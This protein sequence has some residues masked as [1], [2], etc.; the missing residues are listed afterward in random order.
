MWEAARWLVS[1]TLLES[2]DTDNLSAGISFTAVLFHGDDSVVFPTEEEYKREHKCKTAQLQDLLHNSCVVCGEEREDSFNFCVFRRSTGEKKKKENAR[3]TDDEVNGPHK[4]FLL[5]IA[6]EF[7]KVARIFS[8]TFSYSNF[9]F[10]LS[11]FFKRKKKTLKTF[12][13][14]F[15]LCPLRPL[16]SPLFFSPI[17]RPND[18]RS[19]QS[20]AVMAV[21]AYR[22][23]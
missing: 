8:I 12:I 20:E 2:S 7:L 11:S 9:H 3:Q 5:Q 18:S 17:T 23:I 16:S 19:S 6:A 21:S 22:Y 15:L 10:P 1:V 13:S 14:L 4:T